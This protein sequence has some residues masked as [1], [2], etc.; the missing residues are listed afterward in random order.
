MAGTVPGKEFSQDHIRIEWPVSGVARMTRAE[1]SEEKYFQKY[2][3]GE[4]ESSQADYDFIF[5]IFML[6]L[7]FLRAGAMFKI[8]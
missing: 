4:N 2:F 3:K 8:F 1:N 6:G 7:G 5:Q